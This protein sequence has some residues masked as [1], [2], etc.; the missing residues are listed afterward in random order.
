MKKTMNEFTEKRS[1]LK[2]GLVPHEKDGLDVGLE[3]V[4]QIRDI[5]IRIRI[6]GSMHWITDP[7]PLS[8]SF[9]F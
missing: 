3:S 5:L 9:A 2:D 8:S 6:L 4:F 1:C 7:D